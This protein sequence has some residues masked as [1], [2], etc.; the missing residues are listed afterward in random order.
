MYTSDKNH[1][2]LRKGQSRFWAKE[3]TLRLLGQVSRCAIV[4]VFNRSS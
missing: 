4:L 1:S 2:T 3:N